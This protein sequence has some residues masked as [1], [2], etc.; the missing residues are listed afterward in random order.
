MTQ[1]QVIHLLLMLNLR[2]PLVKSATIMTILDIV[3]IY[4]VMGKNMIIMLEAIQRVRDATHLVVAVAA[5]AVGPRS[6]F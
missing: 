2:P 6:I 5:A 1:V 3:R 4:A